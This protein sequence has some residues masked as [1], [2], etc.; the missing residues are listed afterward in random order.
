MDKA[1]CSVTTQKMPNLLK[2]RHK[3]GIKGFQTQNPSNLQ[4][5]RD[6]EGSGST[7]I[8]AHVGRLCVP[9]GHTQASLKGGKMGART[10]RGKGTEGKVRQ[11]LCWPAEAGTQSEAL[12][13]RLLAPAPGRAE[14][15]I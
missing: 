8:R 14:G 2:T 9:V 7:A 15:R 5:Q 1:T 12:G 4:K 6:S 11:P 13:P 3:T 10:G